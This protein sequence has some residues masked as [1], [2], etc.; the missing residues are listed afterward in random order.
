[1]ARD[2]DVHSAIQ[3]ALVETNAFDNVYLWGLPEDY[4]SGSSA[5]AIAVIEPSVDADRRVGFRRPAG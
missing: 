2:R 4:G 5:T 1:M 3:A